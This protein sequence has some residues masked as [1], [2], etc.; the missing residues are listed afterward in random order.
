MKLS[1]CFYSKLILKISQIEG[2]R[3]PKYGCTSE[4]FGFIK[5][6]EEVMPMVKGR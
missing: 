6:S 3:D 5:V 4:P 2:L 1:N